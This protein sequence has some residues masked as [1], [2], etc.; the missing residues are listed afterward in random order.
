M[1]KAAKVFRRRAD[2]FETLI[3]RARDDRWSSPSPC[4]EWDARAVV[5][6]V[7]ATLQQMLVP[8]GRTPSPAP[9]V[10]EDPLEAFRAA[11]KD[12]EAVLDDPELS[13]RQVEGPV[14]V[15]SAEDMIDRTVSSDIVIHGWDLAM[16]TGQNA[17][18]HALDVRLAF[19][20]AVNMPPEMR[21]PGA[22]GPGIVVFGPEVKVPPGAPAQDRLLGMLGRNPK[23]TPPKTRRRRQ[24]TT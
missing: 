23:W 12:V 18:I 17:R 15:M 14:G 2:T 3:A 10:D 6:H 7:V 19:P 16:A 21:E 24:A 11:R 9:T 8:V 20:R 4:D 22:F 5:G 1:N 13:R